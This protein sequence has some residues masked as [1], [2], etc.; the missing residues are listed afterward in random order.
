MEKIIM[1]SHATIDKTIAKLF[2]RLINRIS[3]S[4]IKTWFSSDESSMGGI[5]VGERWFD[6]L[7]TNIERSSAVISI[8]TPLIS[9]NC[10]IISYLAVFSTSVTTAYLRFS[11]TIVSPS[12]CPYSSLVLA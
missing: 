8:L 2:S 1:I 6:E 12:K 9:H 3:L 5:G 10:S 11:P 7:K 4:Q